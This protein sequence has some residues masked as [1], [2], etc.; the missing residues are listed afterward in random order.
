VELQ[1]ERESGRQILHF[2]PN[3]TSHLL[4]IWIKNDWETLVPRINVEN[5]I[6]LGFVLEQMYFVR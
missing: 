5:V 4:E 3:N 2:T 6:K 1:T